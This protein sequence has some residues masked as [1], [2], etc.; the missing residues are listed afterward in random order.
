MNC[1]L[2][3]TNT[4]NNTSSKKID[5]FYQFNNNENNSQFIDLSMQPQAQLNNRQGKPDS[6][7]IFLGHDQQLQLQH[8]QPIYTKYLSHDDYENAAT[9]GSQ[10]SNCQN[11]HLNIQPNDLP[12]DVDSFVV[13]LPNLYEFDSIELT[14]NHQMQIIQSNHD[15]TGNQSNNCNQNQFTEPSY[16]DHDFSLIRLNSESNSD[17]FIL[18]NDTNNFNLNKNEKT[19]NEIQMSKVEILNQILLSASNSSASST[20]SLSSSYLSSST[21]SSYSSSSSSSLSIDQNQKDYLNTLEQSPHTSNSKK[22]G[23]G[24]LKLK[25]K[26]KDEKI[27]CNVCGHKSSGFHYGSY[28]CEACKLFF[29]YF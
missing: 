5:S 7:L 20:S 8:H 1:F 19:A 10:N 12:I 13:N 11:Y 26:R 18:N 22:L 6:S 28:T 25:I 24:A 9:S 23:S 29:R 27:C 2:N 3:S 4:S 14:N 17:N 21:P 16:N 15:L